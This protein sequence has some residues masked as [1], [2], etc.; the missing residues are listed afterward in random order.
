[1][2]AETEERQR[3]PDLEFSST[4]IEE[5]HVETNRVAA[6]SSVVDSFKGCGFSGLKINKDELR[7]KM[8]I[9]EYLRNAMVEAVIKKEFV[10][11]ADRHRGDKTGTA[12][13]AAIIVFINSKSGGH[14]GPAL[15]T[16]LQE[17][18][19]EEQ[20]FDLSDVKPSDFI[21]HGLGCLEK[22]ASFGDPCAQE[23][24]NRVRIMVAGGDGTVGWVLGTIG[25]LHLENRKPIPPVGVIPLGTGN[26]LSRSFGWGGSFPFAWKPSI[27]R[28][29][30]RA[31]SGPICRLD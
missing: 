1:M 16:K 6:R 9:P 3:S 13:E 26:D 31:I 18:I 24:R 23:T 14:H 2:A 15:K 7:R 30:S 21:Q 29:L 12:P 17:L 25:E 20:V 8:L 11:D 22:L 28:S 10:Y 27:K 4:E 19:S 5:N